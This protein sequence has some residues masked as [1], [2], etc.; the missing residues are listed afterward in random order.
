MEKTSKI[1]LSEELNI[2]KMFNMFKEANSDVTISYETYR[3]AFKKCNISCGYP[4]SD[5]CSI[6]DKFLAEMKALEQRTE[7]SETEKRKL[8][9]VN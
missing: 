9:V 6:C 7:T 8:T 2:T 1:Y 5:T 4:R 3:T